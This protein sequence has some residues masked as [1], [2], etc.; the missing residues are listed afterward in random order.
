[1]GRQ[2][3]HGNADNVRQGVPEALIGIIVILVLSASMSTLSS[4]VW[5]KL[6][7]FQLICSGVLFPK[8][9]KL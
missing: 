5:F 1:M 6:R 9:K 7:N 2:I 3:R 8:M 4:I